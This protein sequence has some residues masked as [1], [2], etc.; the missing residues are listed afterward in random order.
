MNITAFDPGA[1]AAYSELFGACGSA[2]FC[3]WWH[4]Q[5]TAND[6]L[7]RC[8]QE[9]ERNR[10]EQLALNRDEHPEAQG[11]LAFEGP[12]A[13]G[14]MKLAPRTTLRKLLRQ[15]AYRGLYLGPDDAI[16]SI[17]CL[18]VHPE[19]R[20]NGV[21]RAMVSASGDFVRRWGGQAVEAYPR[22]SGDW[23]YDEHAWMGTEKLFASSGFT[24][25]AGGP[26]YP[27]MRKS[28]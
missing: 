1:A 11:L 8:I 9:P 6:W 25:I 2:C 24:R 16:W 14:W 20:K 26:A 7:A 22:H 23:T 5:G 10:N 19:Y 3:R 4:F 18:L 17:G 28:V 12:R 15:G 21:A 27:V 13:I